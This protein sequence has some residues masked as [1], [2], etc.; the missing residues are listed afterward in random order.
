MTASALE[1]RIELKNDKVLFEAVSLTSPDRPLPVDYLPPA[2]D[3]QGFRG[4]ELLLMALG[5][6]VSTSIVHVL[7]KGGGTISAFSMNLAGEKSE[8][9]MALKK[10]DLEVRL[11]SPDINKDQLDKALGIAMN[12]SPVLL[13]IRGSVEVNVRAAISGV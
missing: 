7:R 11:V 1:A 13:A 12:L 8:N 5:G 10:A 9:P 2:G 6:C 3:G 4:L